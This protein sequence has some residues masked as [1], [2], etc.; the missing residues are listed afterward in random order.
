MPAA[1]EWPAKKCLLE[2]CGTDLVHRKGESTSNWAK[3]KYCSLSHAQMSKAGQKRRTCKSE[4]CGRPVHAQDLCGSGY[5]Q[6]RA[7]TYAGICV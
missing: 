3:R 2:D 5:Q 7:G 1:K 6:L 4:G